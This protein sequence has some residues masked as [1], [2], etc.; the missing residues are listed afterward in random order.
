LLGRYDETDYCDRFW[1][2][3]VCVVVFA[4][5]VLM[6]PDSQLSVDPL[7]SLASDEFKMRCSILADPGVFSQ[8]AI[9]NIPA[10]PNDR[11]KITFP[12]QQIFSKACLVA[13]AP[14][15]LSPQVGQ[16]VVFGTREISISKNI[17][18]GA[19]LN[20]P[21]AADFEIEGGPNA[22]E[23][24]SIVLSAESAQVLTIDRNAV[25]DAINKCIIRTSCLRNASSGNGIVTR[26]L[27]AKNLRL[28]RVGD[29]GNALAIRQGRS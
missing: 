11:S 5:W 2:D 13:A 12:S 6:Y 9:I 28:R 25:Q 7:C 17:S 16:S 23:V 14:E 1:R 26:F 18:A 4:A 20:V 29:C 8:G 21:E 24:R 22:S 15:D 19:T 27:V 10:P 3:V